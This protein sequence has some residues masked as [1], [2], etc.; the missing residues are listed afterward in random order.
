MFFKISFCK[1]MVVNLKGITKHK[2]GHVTHLTMA[3]CDFFLKQTDFSYQL[4]TL[5]MTSVNF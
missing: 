1:Q 3:F 5:E 2:L 4:S